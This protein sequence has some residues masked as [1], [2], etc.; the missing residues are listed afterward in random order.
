MKRP[1]PTR[2]APSP[3]EPPDGSRVR[4]CLVAVDGSDASVHALVWSLRHAT[5]HGM[6]VEVLTVWPAHHSVLV[7]EVPG[8]FCAPRWSARAAQQ[9]AI[10]SALDTVP[11]AQVSSST[12]EN[13]DTAEAIVRAS[14][15]HDLV[16]L[17]ARSGP[18]RHRLTDQVLGEAVCDV[19]VVAAPGGRRTPPV[20]RPRGSTH[21]PHHREG[22]QS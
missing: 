18:G 20:A 19:V 4:T 9:D 21:V 1:T 7:H 13:A 11:E 17:G 22:V 2:S 8:H 14:A 6:R 10:S 3:S 16:V 5:R 15:R 12:L